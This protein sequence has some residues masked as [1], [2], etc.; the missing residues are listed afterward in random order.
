VAGL[1]LVRLGGEGRILGPQ[2]ARR[3][4]VGPGLLPFGVGVHD[5]GQ[6]GVTPAEVAGLVGVGVQAG[7]GQGTL[8]LGVLRRQLTEPVE[9][10]YSSM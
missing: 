7:I 10:R 2:L 5:R 9:H 3:R 4:L 6:L 1:E 8:Q